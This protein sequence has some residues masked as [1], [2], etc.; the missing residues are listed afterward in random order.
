MY[1][2]NEIF[3]SLQGEGANTGTPAV[4]VRFSGCNLSCF[5]CDT[6][7]SSYTEM[8]V[9]DI[10]RAVSAFPA[11][12]V[13]LT[14]GEPALQ[15]DKKLVDALHAVNK[16]LAIETNGTRPLPSGIDYITVSPKETGKLALSEADE[17]KVVYVGQDVEKY[18]EWI[19]ASRYFLQPCSNEVDGILSDNREEVIRYCLDHP[20]WRLSLQTHKILNIR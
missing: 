2:V 12:M 5:F 16:F 11:K 9:E 19:S 10:V 7:F 1:R 4:F 14:G 3:Y 8:S 20:N 15:V 17:V 6:D 18:R 13:V